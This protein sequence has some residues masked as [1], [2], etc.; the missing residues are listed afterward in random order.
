MVYNHLMTNKI[1]ILTASALLLSACGAAV[2]PTTT[3]SP[4]TAPSQANVFTSIKDAITKKL[5]L[6]CVYSD[7]GQQTTTYINGSQVRFSGTGKEVGVEGIM[8]DSKFY[9]WNST[10]KKG[11]VLDIAKMSGA[12]MGETPVKSVDDVVA[13]LEAKKEN[14]SISPE[15]NSMFDIPADVTF[16]SAPDFSGL[17]K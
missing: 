2:P 7:N 15:S 6:K 16:S 14:C 17:G 1:L 8:K 13:Q 12:K 11:M 3:V 5:T 9:L 4:T 10:D